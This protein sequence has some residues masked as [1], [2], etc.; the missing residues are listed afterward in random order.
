M[1]KVAILLLASF[2]A[3]FAATNSEEPEGKKGFLTK[4][5][6]AERG[7]FKDCRLEVITCGYAGCFKDWNPGDPIK[8]DD[9][10]LYVHDEQKMY[11]IKLAGLK[12]HQLDKGIN[13]DEVTIVGKVDKQNGTIQAER[14][15]APPPPKK[16]FFKGC[17]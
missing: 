13:R 1:K 5:W 11:N 14:M 8:N 4:Q 2:V 9:Y 7:M 16:S 10:V 12:P 3:L 6:C 17:L 15:D